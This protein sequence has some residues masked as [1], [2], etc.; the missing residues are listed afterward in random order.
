ME[1]FATLSVYRT[2]ARYHQDLNNET[3]IQLLKSG[4][5]N[6]F[7]ELFWLSDAYPGVFPVANTI[8][9]RMTKSVSFIA[10]LVQSVFSAAAAAVTNAL[11]VNEH[12]SW[13]N[14][15]L[16]SPDNAGLWRLRSRKRSGAVYRT[17][18]SKYTFSR[19]INYLSRLNS[20]NFGNS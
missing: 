15:L 8:L 20:F 2:I 14:Q 12:A 18:G 6:C 7:L 10:K 4:R 3:Q 17:D 13:Y 19:S 5:P 16:Q 1:Q 9:D 11:N